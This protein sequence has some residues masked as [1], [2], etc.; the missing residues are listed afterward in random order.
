MRERDVARKRRR[1]VVRGGV[2]VLERVSSMS[3]LG[4]LLGAAAVASAPPLRWAPRSFDGPATDGGALFVGGCRNGWLKN[5]EVDGDRTQS[6]S[7]PRTRPAQM[8]YG[9]TR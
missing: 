3:A 5:D 8:S 4:S 1:T 7:A 2:W 6:A 9:A